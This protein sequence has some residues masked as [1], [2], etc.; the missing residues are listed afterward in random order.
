[1]ENVI[2]GKCNRQKARENMQPTESAGKHATCGKRVKTCNP[3]K[4]RVHMQPTEIT[5]R[6]GGKQV[7]DGTREH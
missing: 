4:A 6:R 1:M 2:V 5:D 7:T 3:R